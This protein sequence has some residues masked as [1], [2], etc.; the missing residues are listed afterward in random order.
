VR[1]LGVVTPWNDYWERAFRYDL[2]EIDGRVRPRTSSAAVF[3]DV[4]YGASH[5]PRVLWHGLETPT[6]ML[7]A[8][9]PMS[10]RDGF[11]LTEFDADNFV[12]TTQASRA[13][14]IAANH[15]GII[16]D[17]ATASTLQRFLA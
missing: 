7:R 12:R 2:V 13:E 10:G 16:V 1:G 14:A 4:I 6:L 8:A 5:D 11:I 15:F 3:E 9:I 17:P